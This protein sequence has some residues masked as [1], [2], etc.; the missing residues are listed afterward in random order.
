MKISQLILVFALIGYCFSDIDDCSS[1]FEVKLQSLCSNID[2]SNCLYPSHDKCYSKSPCSEGTDTCSERVHPWANIYKCVDGSDGQCIEKKKECSDYDTTTGD[3]CGNLDPGD[4]TKKRCDSPHLEDIVSPR[5]KSHFNLCEDFEDADETTCRLNI[6]S[7]PL[8]ECIWNTESTKCETKYK[9]C[10][11]TSIPGSIDNC[12]LLPVSE[13]GKTAGKKCI[14]SGA[15]CVEDY[16]HCEDYK[17]DVSSTCTDIKPL[18]LDEINYDVMKKCAFD[19]SKETKCYEVNK[20]VNCGDYTTG[21]GNPELC[22]SLKSSDPENKRC[23]YRYKSDACEDQYK[24]CELYN[25][26]EV[27]NEAD[28]KN[29]I[30]LEKSKKCIW[31]S[32]YECETADKECNYYKSYLP[33]EFCTE[34]TLKDNNKHCMLIRSECKENYINCAA[35][36]GKDKETCENISLGTPYSKCILERD[37]KCVQKTLTC[38]E[39]TTQDQCANAKPSDD[40]KECIFYNGNCI[41][42]YKTCEDY[43]GNNKLIC[44]RIFQFNGKKCVFDSAKCKSYKKICEEAENEEECKLIEKT[45]VSNVDRICYFGLNPLDATPSTPRCFENY[46]YCSDFRENNPTFCNQIKPYDET[47]ENIDISYHCIDESDGVGCKKKLLDCSI[48]GTNATFCE[49]ISN[50]LKQ[51][52]NNKKYCRFI[53]GPCT[54]DY[55]TCGSYNEDPFVDEDCSNIKPNN[56]LTHHCNPENEE[57]KK[58]CKEVEQKDCDNYNSKF[59]DIH[60]QNLCINIKP[61]CF[62]TSGSKLCTKTY[63]DGYGLFDSGEDKANKCKN[64]AVTDQKKICSLNAAETACEEIDKPEEKDSTTPTP[65]PSPSPQEESTQEV[66]SDKEA[67]SSSNETPQ[68]SPDQG[69]NS[70]SKAK[71]I[72]MIIVC[73]WLLFI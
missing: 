46:K 24:T 54:E 36:K 26:K 21:L 11:D 38:L 43:Q 51:S 9:T 58:I 34:I 66:N 52:T 48:A 29:V 68:N 72:S 5:C 70:G 44:E 22:L 7:D 56:Y 55:Y 42:N 62:Y 4:T 71:G 19:A 37:S 27:K 14:F 10:L 45:G 8:R 50:N 49:I 31:N 6:P 16:A 18:K 69:N 60:F 20:Y 39:A 32:D 47:G 59:E 28:C 23:V 17:E 15:S 2:S 13:A 35:Y 41:E 73:L 64:L 61:Y 53:N 3:Q 25:N 33:P 12:H 67:H 30:L 1:E 57:G 40:K 63:C 65:S